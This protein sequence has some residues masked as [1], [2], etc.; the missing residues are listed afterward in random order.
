VSTLERWNRAAFAALVAPPAV[1]PW[2]DRLAT[3]AARGGP[4]VLACLL[5][6][7]WLWGSQGERSRRSLLEAAEAG[8][9]GLGINQLIARVYFHPRPYMLGIARPLL[10][11]GF[12]TSFPSDHATLLFAVGGYLLAGTPRKAAGTVCTALA[13]L[14]SWGRVYAGVHFPLDIMGSLVVAAASGMVVAALRGPAEGAHRRLEA[15]Y[16]RLFETWIRRGWVRG[17]EPVASAPSTQ[18]TT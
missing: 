4:L 12:E 15:L 14:T 9:L 18:G 6:A 11:H 8:F 7:L 1:S 3:A 10:S 16:A 13:L 2:L 5:V 17:V